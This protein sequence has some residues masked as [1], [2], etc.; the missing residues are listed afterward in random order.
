MCCMWC[1]SDISFCFRHLL[2]S[3]KWKMIRCWG[4]AAAALQGTTQW[5]RK[6]GRPLSSPASKNWVRERTLFLA[7]CGNSRAAAIAVGY[8][9]PQSDPV[10][11]ITESS[12]HFIWAFII[13]WECFMRPRKYCTFLWSQAS[14]Y[15]PTL[16]LANVW[17]KYVVAQLDYHLHLFYLNILRIEK[18]NIAISSY[19]P[20]TFNAKR[21][22]LQLSVWRQTLVYEYEK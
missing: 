6:K 16:F 1:V 21:K 9:S 2:L 4:A 12:E 5:R 14:L 3:T 18:Y 13:C 17:S 11:Q 10:D 20:P 15:L 7:F 19:Q 8:G 22:L